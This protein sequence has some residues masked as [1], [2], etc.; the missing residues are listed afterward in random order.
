MAKFARRLAIICIFATIFLSAASPAFGGGGR[1][2]D[3][4]R[5]DELIKNREHEEAVLI[6]TDFARRNPDKF[7][8]AQMRLRKI[9]LIRDEFNRTA[10]KLIDTLINHPEDN[11]R[12]LELS[13]RLY[14]LE[15]ENSPLLVNFV[16]R[17]R[18]IAQFNYNRNQLRGIMERGRE[19]LDRGECAAAMLVYAEGLNFMRD[20]FY[21][22]D[23]GDAI[24]NEVRRQTE[25]IN[26]MLA[27]FP[28][29]SSQIAAISTELVRAVNTGDIT[30]I[31]E[32]TGRLTPAMN[33]FIAL[34]QELYA[35]DSSLE[36]ILNGIRAATQELNDRNHLA[37]I[38]MVINGRSDETIQEGM[39][40]AFDTQWRISIGSVV[41]AYA[42]YVA[43]ENAAALAVFNASDFTAGAAAL[44]RLDSYIN[45]TPVYFER[46]R[47]LFGSRNPPSIT[48]FGSTV[49]NMDIHQYLEI[50]ALNESNNFLRQAANAANN[51]NIDRTSLS[52]WQSGNINAEQALNNEQQTRN[53]IAGI[54]RTIDNIITQATGVNTEIN[55]HHKVEH[56]TNAINAIR[57]LRA[58]LTADELQ[59]A[60]RYYTIAHTSLN[61]VLPARRSQLER[62]RSF[63]NGETETNAGG[64]IIVH[65]YPSEALLELNSLLTL[66]TAD[67]QTGNTILTQYR[68]EQPA[69]IADEGITATRT[70]HQTT[71][72]ELNEL[73]AQCMVMAETAGTRSSQAEA[74]RQEGERFFRDAQSAFQRREYDLARERI[75]RADARFLESLEIQESASVRQM[76]DTQ[77][78]ALDNQIAAAAYDSILVEVRNMVTEARNFYYSGNFLQAED[79]LLRAGNRWRTIN[80]EENSEV[81]YWLGIVRTAM[82]TSS[83]RVIPPT[84]PLYA[85]M[86]Q[87][88]SQAQRN[89][90]EGVRLVNSG[91]RAQGLARFDEAR[92]LTQEVRLLF[93]INQEAGLLELRIEQFLDPPAFNAAF[94]QRLT[95]ARAG[96]RSRSMEA[97][98]DLLNLAEI[99]PNY[100]NMRSIVNQAEIDIGLRPPPPNP[101]DIAQSGELI[102]SARRIYDSNQTTQFNAAIRQLDQA[103]QLNPDNQEAPRLRDMIVARTNVPPNTVLS[104]EDE[105]EYQRALRETNA[106]NHFVALAIVEQLLQNQR[107]RNV[108]KLIELQRRIRS[109][110]L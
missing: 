98:A 63:L 33:N 48:L 100:P 110:V 10:D 39:L 88:L 78:I 40:G 92:K 47:Q 66:L 1:E 56:I 46:H 21:S 76:R 91:Q 99:N 62:G 57:S 28:Q 105:A 17:T 107:N 72:N 59:S 43:R 89:Y 25:R 93:P 5:A 38:S 75:Q 102:A 26:S 103:I 27:S 101:A 70:N 6:L 19:H 61:N 3:L 7:D 73:R 37:F 11:E 86:S 8:Q 45:M 79:R 2:G 13:Q 60:Q 34:K 67:L 35:A 68:N 18:E 90:E 54:Q 50:R 97:F 109:M 71:V 64:S 29:Q 41:D 81:I 20:E 85:E 95:R 74:Y 12:I 44:N 69:L 22:S 42:M 94:E 106:G 4:A 83:S 82:S 80:T 9:Y 96:T 55:T 15:N 32:I 31:N 23:Y 49:L 51:Q 16:S 30:R 14:S 24:E 53:T 84:A 108:T 77:L 65:R 58:K 52:R 104:R 36:R 87:L